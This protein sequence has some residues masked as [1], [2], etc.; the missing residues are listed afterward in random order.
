[1]K[2]QVDW[3]KLYGHHTRYS[4]LKKVIFALAGNSVFFIVL[5]HQ[6]FYEIKTLFVIAAWRI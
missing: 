4:L 5:P 2:E 1:M 3:T 6:L